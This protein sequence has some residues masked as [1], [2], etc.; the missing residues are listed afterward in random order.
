MHLIP[1]SWAHWHIFLSVFP[2]VGLVFALGFYL[3]GLVADNDLMKRSCLVVFAVLGALA[4][5]TYLSGD[6]TMAA[7]SSDAMISADLMTSHFVWGIVALAALAITGVAAVVALWRARGLGRL[8][9]PALRLV[10]ALALVALALM[11]VDG[12]LGWQVNHHELH[13]D[14]AAQRTPQAWSH[15]HMILNHF[16]TVGFAFALGFYV[17]GL[18]GNDVVT[19]RTSLVVFVL[20][21]VLGV[22]TYVTGAAS[23]WA[24]TDPGV[25]GISKPAINAHRDMALLTL[26]GLAFTGVAAWIELWRFRHLARFSRPSLYLI[27]GFAII[28]LAVMAETGHRG[29]QI[30]HPEIRIASDALP[31][32]LKAG[33]TRVIEQLINQVIWFVPWQTV[34]FFGFSLIFGTALVVSLRVL[35]FWK[36]VSFAAVHRLLPLGVFGVV[37]NVFSGMLI[38]LADSSR[39]LNA[40]TFAPK[41]AL[42]AIGAA[43]VLYFSLSERLWKVGGGDDAPAGAKWVAALV[44]ISWTGV[45]MGG[46]LISYL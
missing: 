2:S 8:S 45:I 10:L 24:L 7:L 27:L 18:V 6:R 46:R 28:T 37:M 40:P 26:F 30:N 25:A 4:I 38:M 44:L 14:A 41:I 35:G 11:V 33:Y 5:P 36:S 20:C 39:Y 16:P 9:Q 21:A 23:T 15:A 22:P 1:Q 13:L 34:H 19:Q 3:A 29:G 17:I 42:I 31:T 12:E 32:D 43:A